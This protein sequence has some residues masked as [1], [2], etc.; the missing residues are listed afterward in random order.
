MGAGVAQWVLEGASTDLDAALTAATGA[1]PARFR[2]LGFIPGGEVGVLRFT[3]SVLSG[4]PYDFSGLAVDPGPADS[5]GAV[6]TLADFGLLVLV[7]GTP[8]A[9]RDWIEQ[10]Q[11]RAPDL[12]VVAVVSAAAEPLVRPYRDM[13]GAR[14]AGV[15]SGLVGAAQYEQQTAWAGDAAGRL[16]GLGGGLLAAAALL[17]LGNLVHGLLGAGLRRARRR[18]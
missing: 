17:A 5:N 14:L 10:T 8:E 1:T 12:P 11:I 9:A 18:G 13:A 3:L 2:N 6:E 15:V 4:F 7:S 16:G